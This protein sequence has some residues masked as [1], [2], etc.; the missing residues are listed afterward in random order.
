MCY[1]GFG[2]RNGVSCTVSPVLPT[3]KQTTMCDGQRELEQPPSR[4]MRSS[5]RVCGIVWGCGRRSIPKEGR[6]RGT[7][8]RRLCRRCRV[9]TRE[10]L[11]VG[12]FDDFGSACLAVGP[13]VARRSSVCW[14]AW[15]GY[16]LD[17]NGPGGARLDES[18]LPARLLPRQWL[19]L[20]WVGQWLL[21]LHRPLASRLEW[22]DR[23]RQ[24][25]LGA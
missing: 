4:L 24:S 2:H 6:E 11:C 8:P 23:F 7:Q 17:A 12:F 22:P 10:V 18:A 15:A 9:G 5:R 20:L 21:S 16:R 25:R 14:R 13:H 19:V 1:T 3:G